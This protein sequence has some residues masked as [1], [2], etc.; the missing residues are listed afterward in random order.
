MDERS[1]KPRL[2]NESENRGKGNPDANITAFS[3]VQQATGQAPKIELKEER[4]GGR[5][6]AHGWVEGWE[7]ESGKALSG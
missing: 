2:G 5:T 3:I 6:W 1:S 7:R 4:G